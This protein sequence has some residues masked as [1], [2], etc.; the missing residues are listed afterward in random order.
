MFAKAPVP[1]RVKTRL[2][3]ELG[4]I[5]AAEV[6]RQI[7]RRVVTQLSGGAYRM[8]IYFDPPGS[9]PEINAWLG[10]LEHER[11]QQPAGD[12]GS[13]L[14]QGFRW[15]FAEGRSVCVVGTDIPGLDRQPVEDAFAILSSPGGPDLVVGPALDGGY[16]LLGLRRPAPELFRDIPWST[17]D[18]L[19][20]TMAR[21]KRLGLT[22][23]SLSALADVDRPE[24]LPKEFRSPLQ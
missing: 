3:E 18:V 17:G 19:E 7:G 22:V 4:A 8:V 14:T 5:R 11:L 21:A 23:H 1:G 16:Y 2:A 15:G 20:A 13:R 6:Y 24:D 10:D 9:E 12:L